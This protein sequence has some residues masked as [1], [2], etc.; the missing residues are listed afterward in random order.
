[1]S[2]TQDVL[3]L[4]SL[5]VYLFALTDVL[6]VIASPSDVGPTAVTLVTL[7]PGCSFPHEVGA[8]SPGEACQ[9]YN[10]FLHKSIHVM[11]VP[12]GQ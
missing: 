5:T 2:I 1:M 7:Q 6:H 3:V 11:Y 12:V 4:P 10:I 9:S 8:V